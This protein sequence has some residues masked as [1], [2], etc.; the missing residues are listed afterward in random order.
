MTTSPAIL[1]DEHRNM[2]AIGM[3]NN[4]PERAEAAGSDEWMVGG[5][6]YFGTAEIDVAEGTVT[7]HVVGSQIRPELVGVGRVR[8][9]EFDVTS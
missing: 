2:S 6:A 3:P 5:F 1:Y 9:Y 7:H 4:L 8:Y